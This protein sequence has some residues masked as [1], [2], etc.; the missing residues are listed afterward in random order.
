[1]AIIMLPTTIRTTEEMIKLVPTNLREGALAL[2]AP[3]W[4][5]ALQVTFPAALSGILTGFMLSLARASGET[6]PLLF[7]ALGN[8]RF[9]LAKLV[10]GGVAA[11]QSV[12]TILGNILQQPAD[13]LALTLLQIQPGS[14]YQ[15]RQPIVGGGFC[16]DVVGIDHQHSRQGLG[17]ISGCQTAPLNERIIWKP[18]CKINHSP[19]SQMK[20]GKD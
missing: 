3:E 10:S 16:A 8:D 14:E 11:G 7:T 2:G 4:K 20:I 5:T 6:A 17:R 15:S 13:S 9:D 12:F 1:M 18:H 19:S